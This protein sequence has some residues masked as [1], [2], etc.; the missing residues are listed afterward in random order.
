MNFEKIIVLCGIFFIAIFGGIE[1]MI[2]VEEEIE[3]RWKLIS[4]YLAFVLTWMTGIFLVVALYIAIH[5]II[6]T[7]DANTNIPKLTWF[8][9]K[10]WIW[11]ENAIIFYVL[12]FS[13]LLASISLI[14]YI[15][16]DKQFSRNIYFKQF[17]AESDISQPIKFVAAFG[18]QLFLLLLF[19]VLLLTLETTNI[20]LCVANVIVIVLLAI[21]GGFTL[22]SALYSDIVK[23][24]V[25]SFLMLITVITRFYLTR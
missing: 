19:F 12:L 4:I 1:T 3:A 21:F 9:L 5:L 13:V 6:T 17:N 22:K 2:L 18:L 20:Y 25:Y 14:T 11:S 10:P 7:E 24:V 15:N 16:A 23:T 8:V